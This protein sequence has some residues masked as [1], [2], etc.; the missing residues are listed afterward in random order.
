MQLACR[1]MQAQ[2]YDTRRK[3]FSPFLSHNRQTAINFILVVIIIDHT[4]QLS[5]TPGPTIKDN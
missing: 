1:F 4:N 5:N 2:G 3:T